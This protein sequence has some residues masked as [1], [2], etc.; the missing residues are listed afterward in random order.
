MLIYLFLGPINVLFKDYL[1]YACVKR[2]FNFFAA[3][4]WI[5]F[6]HAMITLTE[7]SIKI[8][9]CILRH[10]VVSILLEM[11]ASNGREFQFQFLT[12]TTKTTSTATICILAFNLKDTQTLN[13][14]CEVLLQN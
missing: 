3:G 5:N 11:V 12:T 10:D 6:Y 2:H 9:S 4:K 13:S 1:P 7:V 8:M 14:Q